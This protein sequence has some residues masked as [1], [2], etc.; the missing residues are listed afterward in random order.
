MGVV[1]ILSRKRQYTY[2]DYS[3]LDDNKRYELVEGRLIMAPAPGP[4]HQRILSDLNELIK[5]FAKENNLGVVYFSPLDVML[6]ELN[7]VQPDLL[8]IANK[9]FNIID[10]R[11]VKGVPDLI[12]EI[13]SENSLQQDRIIKKELYE[14]FGVKEYWIVDPAYKA[15]EVFTLKKGKYQ[16]FKTYTKD[17]I[18]KSSILRGLRISLKQIFK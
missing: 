8:F 4:E 13:L 18:V 5:K 15:I 6:D 11:Y 9:N 12:I 10:K 7:V 17:D 14:K 1:K 16:L 2:N 3:K